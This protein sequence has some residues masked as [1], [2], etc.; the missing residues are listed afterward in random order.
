MEIG[1]D[2]ENN[3]SQKNTNSK[4]KKSHI[5]K[6]LKKSIKE[7]FSFTGD[8]LMGTLELLEDASFSD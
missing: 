5:K 2:K 8:L 4:S 6:I 3:K 7:V 1:Y